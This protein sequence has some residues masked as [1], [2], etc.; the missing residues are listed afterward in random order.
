MLLLNQRIDPG[1]YQ[2]NNH[3][4][5]PMR[6]SIVWDGAGKSKNMTRVKGATHA[7]KRRRKTLSKTKGY[8]YGRSSKEKEA[9]QAWI[10]A[11]QHAFA[12]RK[13][14]KGD[15]RRLWQVRIGA[16]SKPLG[17][18]Y[19][20]LIAS[21]K[22]NK[23]QLDRKILSDLGQNHPETFKRIVQKLK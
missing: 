15:F 8:R 18:S 3:D 20:K 22:E 16:S 4:P 6:R 17:F 19:S 10:R 13:Q 7:I 11:G 14:K 9:K 5:S 12:H 23:I 2:I 21:L 1:F